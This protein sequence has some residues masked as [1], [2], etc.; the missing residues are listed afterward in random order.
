MRTIREDVR[1]LRLGQPTV[2]KKYFAIFLGQF[3][4]IKSEILGQP[5]SNDPTANNVRDI[6]ALFIQKCN[7]KLSEV[8]YIIE[9]IA[10]LVNFELENEILVVI[11]IPEATYILMSLVWCYHYVS[12][13]VLPSGRPKRVNTKTTETKILVRFNQTET[14]NTK[15]KLSVYFWEIK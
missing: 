5:W 2:N 7:H 3:C 9:Y 4:I 10:Y 1:N 14:K 13:F 8:Q 15:P 12:N 11:A 6:S